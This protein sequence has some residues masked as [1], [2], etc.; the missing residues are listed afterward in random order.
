[1]QELRPS[2]SMTAILQSTQDALEC[3]QIDAFRGAFDWRRLPYCF[4][5]CLG[6]RHSHWIR[7][8]DI[9]QSG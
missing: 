1:M 8:V 5:R 4:C 6:T 7:R 3:D 9:S 2:D